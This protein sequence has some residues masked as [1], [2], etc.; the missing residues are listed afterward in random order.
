MNHYLAIGNR[1]RMKIYKKIGVGK[2]SRVDLIDDL[3]CSSES[4]ANQLVGGVNG[5]F[6]PLVFRVQALR[7]IRRSFFPGQTKH[8]GS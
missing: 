8:T 1:L 6:L 7:P 2:E 4:A 5:G 3:R